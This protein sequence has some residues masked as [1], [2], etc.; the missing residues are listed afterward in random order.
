MKCMTKLESTIE[1][2]NKIMTEE[3]HTVISDAIEYLK[4]INISDVVPESEKALYGFGF[5]KTKEKDEECVSFIRCGSV[6]KDYEKILHV[7]D[8]L[9]VYVDSVNFDKYSETIKQF[10]ED[11]RGGLYD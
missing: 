3:N 5:E 10:C 9:I 1:S 2:L 4:K 7:E 6:V 11:I 8:K